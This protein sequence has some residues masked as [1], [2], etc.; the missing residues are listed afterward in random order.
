MAVGWG[1]PWPASASLRGP[2]PQAL[3]LFRGAS[4]ITW[5]RWRSIAGEC[6]RGPGHFW[7]AWRVWVMI[8]CLGPPKKGLV[9]LSSGWR[10]VRQIPT[11]SQWWAWALFG[12]PCW[13]VHGSDQ[14]CTDSGGDRSGS[15]SQ[16]SCWAR[17]NRHPRTSG[18]RLLKFLLLLEGLGLSPGAWGAPI[19]GECRQGAKHF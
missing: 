12:W 9:P 14:V 18:D 19:F 6:R 3:T 16:H 11:S 7:A 13:S 17:Q 4:F 10:D 2:F 5:I 15:S 1:T 8:L